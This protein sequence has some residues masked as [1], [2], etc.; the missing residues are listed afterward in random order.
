MLQIVV[1]LVISLVAYYFLQDIE[2][3]KAARAGVLPATT[4]KRAML[5]FFLF[6]VI[7]ILVHFVSESIA[8]WGGGAGSA[9]MPPK[10]AA[11]AGAMGGGSHLPV[12]DPAQVA[13]ML[14]RIPQDI[15]VGP[16]PF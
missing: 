3:A 13:A 15:Q 8:D 7:L 5:W 2:D 16:V 11:A 9:T 12:P 4:A 14:R 1:S 6:I 10:A